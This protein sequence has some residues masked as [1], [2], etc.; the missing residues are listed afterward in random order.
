MNHPLQNK[1]ILLGVTGSIAC[2]KAADLASKL[3]QAGALVDVVLTESATK[4]ISPL[5]F[6]SVTGRKA[7][8]EADLWKT[9]GHVPHITLGRAA[10]FAIVAPASA[11]TIAKMVQGVADNLLTTTLLAIE[12]PLAIAPAMDGGMYAHPATQANLKALAERG[13]TIWEPNEGHLASGL[14]LKGRMIEAL[15]ILGRTRHKV[16]QLHGPLKGKKVV[17]TA[18]G[19]QEKID[20]VRYITNRSSGKQGYALA[21]A[22]L[23]AGADVI[24]I[25]TPVCIE[26]PEGAQLL[27]VESAEDMKNARF[28]RS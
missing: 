26:P 25:S 17:V 12:C 21:Q 2:Y 15:D 10:D 18:G 6:Q 11:N 8:V 27:M 24:L 5:T 28:A 9:E 4:L 14:N 7:Y 3:T 16:A 19:T 22:A 1:R 20:V 23:D 13:V